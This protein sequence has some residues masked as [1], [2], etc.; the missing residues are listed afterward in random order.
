MSPRKKRKQPTTNH[1]QETVT[2]SA[3]PNIDYALLAKHILEQQQMSTSET[4]L[5]SQEE[6]TLPTTV[7]TDPESTS[8]L[9][10]SVLN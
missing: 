10:N 8:G 2:Q 1:D 3:L 7:A 5:A 6:L 9:I 4:G